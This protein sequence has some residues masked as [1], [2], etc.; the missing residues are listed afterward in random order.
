ML[1]LTVSPWDEPKRLRRQLAEVLSQDSDIV[2]VTLPFGLRKPACNTD[3]MDGS[4]RVISLAGPPVPLRL[5]L[6]FPALRLAYERILAWQLGRRLVDT[7]NISAVFCFTSNYPTLL[8]RFQHVPVIY[9]A[10]DDHAS[11]AGSLF[12][13]KIILRDQA[14]AIALCDRV[15]SVSEVIARKLSQHGKPVH[16][17]YP[18]HNCE[19]LPLDH[20]SNSERLERSVC[21]FGYIDWRI[22]FDLLTFLLN[23]GWYVALIGPV[24]GTAHLIAGLQER[25]P[26]RF[27]VLPAV[28][29]EQAVD[30]LARYEVLIVPY[31][32][33]TAEQAAVMELPNKMFVY[34]SALR[35]VVTTWMPN[36]KLVESGLIY[37][38]ATHDEFLS[39]C[40]RAIEED[41]AAYAARRRRVSQENTW[42]TRRSTLRALIEGADSP[43]LPEVVS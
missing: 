21:F 11:M 19:V 40:L 8:A 34:F 27:D 41:S 42:E 29:A 1:L 43:L 7:A 26:E 16:V 3:R 33:R 2:Y 28:A 6:R 15:V 10:N 14:R 22:D 30:L 17:M 35:P 5:F 9:V 12:A 25:F 18:G 31:H 39:L 32:Y 4:I 13:R 23:N 20:F 37:R 24:I 38:A 36:L